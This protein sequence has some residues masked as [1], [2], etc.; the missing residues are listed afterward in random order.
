[1]KR[2]LIKRN[3]QFLSSRYVAHLSGDGAF[4]QVTCYTAYFTKD[5][6]MIFKP[7]RY[8]WRWCFNDEWFSDLIGNAHD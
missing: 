1:M 3:K 8:K 5:N 6:R 7:I 4:Q 2:K